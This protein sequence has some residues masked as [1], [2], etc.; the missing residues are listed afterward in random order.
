[1]GK[2]KK[3]ALKSLPPSWR[4]D[5]WERASQPEWRKARPQ[6]L[7]VLAVL[8]L[9]GCRNA[10]VEQGVHIRF[11]DDLLAI[12][13]LGAKCVDADGRE[14][15]QPKR[16]Y[17]FKT[18]AGPGRTEHPALN[19]LRLLAEQNMSDG[20]GRALVSHDADYL[21]NSIVDLGK[22]VFPRLRTRIGPYC[23]RHQ[24]A[25]DLKADPDLSLE[26]A[27]KFM[28]HL[29]DYSIGKYGHA[30]HGRKGAERVKAYAVRTSRPIKHSPKVDRLARFKISSAKRRDDKL[31]S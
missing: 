21:Y 23:Y 13:V 26:D 5:L 22:S 17:G 30:I 11:R 8:W 16:H 19:C 20:I 14:R 3:P 2:A 25:S 29:S 4:E 1:M 6:L 15:G 18:G 12:E 10:E 28:G 31:R 7:P 27:A 9:T 24:S